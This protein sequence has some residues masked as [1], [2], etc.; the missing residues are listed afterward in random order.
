MAAKKDISVPRLVIAWL[1][2]LSPV[3]VP[4]PGATRPESVV[5]SAAA[6]EVSLSAD[7]VAE[8]SSGLP[9]SEPRRAELDPAPP[10]REG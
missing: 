4:L 8:I 5:D 9:E 6:A 1:L 10:R 7:E 3:M 2:N